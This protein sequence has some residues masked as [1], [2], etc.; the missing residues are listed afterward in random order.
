L[1][2]HLAATVSDVK[3]ELGIVA[4]LIIGLLPGAARA[5]DYHRNAYGM[6]A[7]PTIYGFAKGSEYSVASSGAGLDFGL[8]YS[9]FFT[10]AFSARLEVRYGTRSMDDI[11]PS[12]LFPGSYSMFRLEESVLEVPVVLQA[13]RRVPVGDHVLRISV[14]GG[15]STKFVLDQKLLGPSGELPEAYG[16]KAADSYRRVGIL[17][18]G[19]ATLDV[20]RRSAIFARLRFDYDLGTAGEP[21]DA[22][23]IRRFWETG[24]YAGFECG[25]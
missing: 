17:L 10:E 19:G 13:D 11:K 18:D 14:G 25:F 15:F 3:H 7:A 12:D 6:Y 1:P 21:T 24:I 16:F 8:Y 2:S 22:S 20:D 5:Q 4:L 23:V 9:R